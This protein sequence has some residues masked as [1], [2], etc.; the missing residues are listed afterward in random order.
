M[1]FTKK[2]LNLFDEPY[3]FYLLV[4]LKEKQVRLQ[5]K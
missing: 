1:Y 5:N 4:I 2:T 3:D